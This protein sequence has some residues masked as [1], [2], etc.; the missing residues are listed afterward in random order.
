MKPTNTPWRMA[1]AIIAVLALSAPS[2][3]GVYKALAPTRGPV[4]AGLA[5]AGF[6]LAYLSLSLLV[7]RPELRRQARAVALAAVI[8]AI[9]LNGLADYADRVIGGLASW[10]DA[11]RLFDPLALA[12]SLIESAPLAGLAYAL[13]SLLHRMAEE[14]EPAER[15]ALVWAR[16][17]VS[18]PNPIKFTPDELQELKAVASVGA[19]FSGYDPIEVDGSANHNPESSSDR[20]EPSKT[21]FCRRCDEGPFDFAELGRHSRTCKSQE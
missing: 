10:P 6:E 14:P 5:A 9:V 7:L 20:P 1:A 12:L 4:A 19:T 16:D 13:A 3:V 11:V 2:A 15:P 21:F 17:Q 18:Y 8:T